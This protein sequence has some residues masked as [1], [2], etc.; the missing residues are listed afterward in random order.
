MSRSGHSPGLLTR[1]R[2]LLGSFG[3]AGTVV[4]GGCDAWVQNDSVQR[5]LAMAESLTKG[6][7]RA[8]LREDRLAR[9]FTEADLSPVFKANGTQNPDTDEYTALAQAKFANWQLLIDGKVRQPLSLS[10]ADLKRL[11]ART[12]I[13][14]HDCVEGWSAIGKWTGVPLGLL[15]KTA[16]L[17]PEARYVVFHCA[18]DYEQS[19]DGSGRYYESIDLKDAFHP[20]TIMAYAM[21]GQD[22]PVA[23]GAPLRLR[24]ERQLGYKHAKYVMRVEV[25]DS[26]LSLGKG[27]GGF[28]EDRGYEWY[29]GI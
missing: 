2:L 15:L 16:G 19:L 5:V 4:L 22:L 29:A 17:M 3:A 18:D 12:Q 26:L 6:S 11:P 9:E 1:R 27:K 14:R 21:N 20:Q 24:V 23:H 13:T 25:V 7:Q 8:L 10:L 28:W